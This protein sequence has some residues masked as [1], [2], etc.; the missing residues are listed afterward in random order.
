[1]AAGLI[2]VPLGDASVDPAE[3]RD[4]AAALQETMAY[5]L[6]MPELGAPFV[7]HFVDHPTVVEFVAKHLVDR[8]HTAPDCEACPS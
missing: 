2:I 7:S 8:G 1:M 4:L 3:L 6:G 5:K